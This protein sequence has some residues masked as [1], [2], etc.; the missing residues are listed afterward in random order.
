MSARST[1]DLGTVISPNIRQ[2]RKQSKNPMK[3]IVNKHR[4]KIN[5]RG[6]SI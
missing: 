3:L 4:V 2:K 5:I 6:T 1:F